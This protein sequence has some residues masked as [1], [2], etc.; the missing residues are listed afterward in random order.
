MGEFLGKHGSSLG[1]GCEPVID[2]LFEQQEAW[3]NENGDVDTVLIG[4]VGKLPLDAQRL[5][6]CL[7][8]RKA[9]ER[10]LQDLYDAQGV[11]RETP[12]FVLLKDGKGAVTR[13]AKSADVFAKLLDSRLGTKDDE[14]GENDKADD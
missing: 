4:L 3:S 6:D 7:Q 8:G 12:T 14:A 5:R 2:L 1:V 9:L 13:G 10:V 11:V